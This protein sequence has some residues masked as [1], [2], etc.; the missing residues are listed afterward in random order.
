MPSDTTPT[1][2]IGLELADSG[3]WYGL[4]DDGN[5]GAVRDGKN[6]GSYRLCKEC[7]DAIVF[8]MIPTMQPVWFR[9]G[10]REMRADSL[11]AP[12]FE[13]MVALAQ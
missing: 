1:K 7:P 4:L 9:T 3:N 6:W 13:W 11:S 5:G 10:P 8:D 2:G 12:T